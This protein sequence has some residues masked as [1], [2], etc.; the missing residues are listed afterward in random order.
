MDAKYLQV[1]DTA[2]TEGN[3]N[4]TGCKISPY[5]S[6]DDI[7]DCQIRKTFKFPKSL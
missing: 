6:F 3:Y 7:I 4:A 1:S 2:H 5:I